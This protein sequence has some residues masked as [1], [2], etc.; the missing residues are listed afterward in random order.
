MYNFYFLNNIKTRWFILF[1]IIIHTIAAYF[2]VGYYSADEHY[3]IIGP[4]EKLLNIETKLTW[5]FDSQIRPWIQPYFYFFIIK[6]FN[7]LNIDNPFTLILI[8]RLISSLIGFVSIFYL[9]TY[10]KDKFNLNN[11]ISKY[12]IFGFWFYAFLHARTSSE[13]LSISMLIFGLIF[14]DKFII[15]NEKRKKFLLSLTSGLFLGLSMLL[16]FQIV[17]SV[18]FIYIWFLVNRFSISNFRYVFIS[19]LII[20]TVLLTGLILDYF[21][22]GNL[23]NTYYNY[24]YANFVIKWFESFGKD[25][26]WHYLT[27]ILLNF[28][29]P[30]SLV[31]IISFGYFWFK[32][33]NNLFTYVSLPVFILLSV[34]SHKELRF[35]FPI[36]IF[37]PFFLSYFISNTPIFFAK[38][39]ITNCIVVLNFIFIIALFIPATE[40]VKIYKFI[41]DN[42]DTINK[43]Y[44]YDDNPYI[45]DD[46]EPRF[47]TSYL[48]KIK[49]YN[50]K[51]NYKDYYLII[52]DYNFYIETINK[53]NC[54]SVFSIYPKIV[55][56]NKNWRQRKFNWYI[57]YCN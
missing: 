41:F 21:G 11:N 4:L 29:P 32:N 30:V 48:P 40:Q 28:F 27:L 47:Y 49:K 36:L 23:N 38:K 8:L 10:L 20:I 37:T 5:E 7:F 14:F 17:T 33:L 12:L 45:I 50:K 3:Q 31:I 46:L 15:K 13:N 53:K 16:K 44:Y 35:I 54:S 24:Y 18:I 19:G 39:F 43:I 25:P 51:E 1:G 6:I 56:L 26:W 9:Y 34:L 57:V 55:N 52:R 2:S 22:Y 42:S